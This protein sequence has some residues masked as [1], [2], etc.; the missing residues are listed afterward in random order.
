MGAAVRIEFSAFSQPMYMKQ[1]LNG[2]SYSC[3]IVTI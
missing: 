3:A 2:G 1:E